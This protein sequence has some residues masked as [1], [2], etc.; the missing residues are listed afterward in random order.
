MP[1]LDR[2]AE[3]ELGF[4]LDVV[5]DREGDVAAVARR[6]RDDRVEDVAERIADERFPTASPCKRL[7]QRELQAGKAVVVDPRIAE[8]LRR[9]RM[10]GIEP[11]LFGIEPEP[12]DVEPLQLRR[13]R[14]VGL[15]LD[16]DEPVR[17]VG[18]RFIDALRIEPQDAGDDG[19]DLGRVP[20]LQRVRIDRHRLLA[21][22]EL[23]A[24]AV[25]DRAP[26]GRDCD[27]LAMLAGRHP[28]EG[29]RAHALEPDGAEKH[30]P[31]D[32]REDGEE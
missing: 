7:V 9:D 29:L 17:A 4:G 14:R 32:D 30:A 27:G 1:F 31:E 13:A 3:D 26:V 22:R 12:R 2:L 25:I 16:V 8:H 20:D 11:P 15:A 5:I 28:P 6:R 24:G 23:D 19:R 18:Q 10:L 21:D